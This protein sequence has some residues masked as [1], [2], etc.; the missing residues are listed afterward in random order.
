MRLL[1]PLLS[2]CL[3]NVP[4]V[5]HCNAD[6]ADAVSWEQQVQPLLTQH[7][8]ECHSSETQESQLRLDSRTSMLRGGDSGEPA[9]IPGDPAG[10][11]LIRL[12]SGTVAEKQMPPEP[13]EH[14]P[15]DQIELLSR[16]IQQGASVPGPDPAADADQLRL[17]HWAFQPVRNLMPP[18][19]SSGWSRNAIDAW[20]VDKLHQNRL[21]PSATA[22]REILIRR[23]YLVM[24][25]LLPTP[26][27]VEEFVQDSRPDAWSRLVE[28]VLSSPHYG[29]RWA[30]YWL[31]LVRF[32]ETNGFETNRERP[33]AWPYRDYVIRSLNEDLPYDQFVLQQIAGDAVGVP[34]A[35]CYLVSGPWDIVRSPDVNLTLMQ[36]QNELDD[37]VNT[38]GTVF[39]GLTLGCARC[40]NHK[41]DPIQQ[42]DYYSMQA[43][44][45]G[46][47]HGD[48]KLPLSEEQQQLV[49]AADRQI[50][51]LREQLQPWLS[52]AG[53]AREPV[54]ALRNEELFKP[55]SVRRIRFTIE[56]SSGA[57][58]CIDELQVFS[59][60]QN[61][62]LAS[63]GTTATAS[64]TL[65]GY[66][67]HQLAHINDGEQGNERSWIS[68]TSGSGWVELLFPEPVTINRIVWGRDAK[69][70]YSDRV[71]TQYRIE[72][73]S[74]AE[75]DDWALLTSS[76]DRAPFGTSDWQ[77]SYDFTSATTAERRV[78]EQT[79]QQLN[80]LREQR[81]QLLSTRTVY[82]GNFSQP[83]PTH[84]LYRGEPQ[85][86]RE[87]VGPDTVAA[88]GQ[89]NLE[90]EAPEQE[91]RLALA[92]WII[93]P[94]NPLT[95]RVIANR[96]WQ[97]HFGSG[98]VTTPSD[99]GTA[100]T[101]PTH[102]ELL[103]WL[104]TQLMQQNWSLKHLHRLILNSAT[105]QQQS[106][107]RPAEMQ[108]DAGTSLWW[109]FPMRRLDAEPLRDCILQVT[110]VL[111][112]QMYGPGFTAFEVQLENVRHYFPKQEFGPAD[113]RRM[114][115]QTRVRQERE[116]VFGVFDCPD[117]SSSVPR[118][119]RS[120]TPLQAF[121]LFNSRFMLQQADLLAERLQRE[122][123]DDQAAQIQ[124]AMQLCCGRSA[125]PD[126]LQEA[127]TLIQQDG[128][129]T[130]CR[131]LL[132]C[133][134][135]AFIP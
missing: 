63:T 69:G 21:E 23:L 56:Q 6:E 87:Q 8:F 90:R 67:I 126:E 42:S 73:C 53:G 2:A 7:C 24:L 61:V 109:R 28:R 4:F 33:N 70:R 58:P 36:R 118:R 119:S 20:I 72:G 134:E 95:P 74:S 114:I 25:G 32:A 45:S 115:Y 39:L 44:F 51:V 54:N 132:N 96:I 43:I 121:N 82:T 120:T 38:T 80:L 85:Q 31:D 117:G 35:T 102:P 112:E 84:R 62:A 27:E 1:L 93:D 78:A 98:L 123:A 91:R 86:Q 10:S 130:F 18:A 9:V 116:A 17:Q 89:L 99:F 81:Q 47:Q 129:P 124:L 57:E 34:E 66:A 15:E 11:Y 110:G 128:L 103:D 131:A 113:W 83:G 75:Q 19:D 94:A 111:S 65:P 125:E 50:P 77:P 29:E 52:Q 64:G 101:A 106:L 100:G 12:I 127:L 26:A 55:V 14:L 79:L 88:L 16:W 104:A 49:T 13:A 68:A 107:P 92:N 122:R 135:L 46:V 3:L 105:W 37:M 41:F 76:A 97:F 40:H 60:D 133:N 108:A 71:P 59:G 22:P 5:S 30:S 48:R